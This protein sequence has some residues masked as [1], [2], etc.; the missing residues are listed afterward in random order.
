[1]ADYS[2]Y[3]GL[4][5]PKSNEKYDVS[6]ANKNN[7]VID[8]ELHKLDLKTQNQ[9]KMFA[10]KESLNSEIERA[11]AK[12]NEI[13]QSLSSEIV[14]AKESENDI[15]NELAYEINRASE[16]ENL[17][18]ESLSQHISEQES[19]IDQAISNHNTS[20][21]SHDDIRNLI[22][23]LAARLNALADSDDTTLDQLSE[24]VAY[25][26][27]NRS[28]IENVTTSK[29]NVSDIIDEL[30][31]TSASKPL[32]ANQG[33][34][35]KELITA[36]TTTVDSKVDKVS[37]KGLS[38]NDY[39]TAEKNKL[40]GIASGAEVNV[41]ADWN[42]TDTNSDAFI[43]NKPAIP[44]KLSELT[45]DTGYT[46]TDSITYELSKSGPMI[47]LTGSDGSETSV[48]DENISYDVVTKTANG[49]VPKLPDET[50]TTKYLRQDGAW[51]DT[52]VP[53]AEDIGALPADGNAVSA[54][55]ATQDGNGNNIA[56]TYAT[57]AV[58]TQSANGLMSAADKTK[59]DMMAK[60]TFSA[61]EPASVPAGEIV[62][63]YE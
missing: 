11:T 39:T 13:S 25:I 20:G 26:K 10:T 37:G 24:I 42:I 27:S 54:T 44:T 22:S 1:M 58:A 46:T 15:S 21:S 2:P 35:L 40:S 38:T 43:K 51:A 5:L 53:T 34:I 60:I 23:D 49:L 7:L 50:T 32:S 56:D 29:I 31:S 48:K 33:R 63:V 8:S 59:L 6:V 55:K 12:E 57:K 47:T 30:T 36:L 41:Q 9:D 16:E 28:L 18:W 4:E 45:N 17:I 61:T 14:R 52:P 3:K 19:S 62:M